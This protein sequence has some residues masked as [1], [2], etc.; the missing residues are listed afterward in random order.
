MSANNAFKPLHSSPEGY[1]TGLAPGMTTSITAGPPG[2]MQT[3]STYHYPGQHPAAYA[4]LGGAGAGAA[5]AGAMNYR[6]VESDQVPLRNGEFDDFS[7]G[8]HDALE[9]IGEEEEPTRLDTGHSNGI[10]SNSP[11]VGGSGHD[12]A[13][14]QAAVAEGTEQ[15]PRPLWQQQRRQSRNLMW[16]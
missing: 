14:G 12:L 15:P 9:R 10:I 7:R 11:S 4:A 2:R 16:M 6:G 3:T 1:E 5:G 8:F 13:D